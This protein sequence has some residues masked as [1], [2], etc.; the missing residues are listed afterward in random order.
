MHEYH[1]L[2]LHPNFLFIHFPGTRWQHFQRFFTIKVNNNIGMTHFA[3][4]V[5]GLQ[6]ICEAGC[7][8]PPIP[9]QCSTCSSK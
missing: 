2:A 9:W 8:P 4:Q 3:I 7:F 5:S 6:H 1:F